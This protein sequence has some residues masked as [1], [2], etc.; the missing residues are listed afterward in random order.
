MQVTCDHLH[1]RSPDPE[2]AASFYVEMLGASITG[3][4]QNVGALRVILDLGGLTTFLEA[5]PADTT[6]APASPFV[7]IEH[8]GLLVAD[9][10]AAAAE[11][12][13]KGATFLVEPRSPA[14]GVKICFIQGPDGVRIE[15]LQRA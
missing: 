2:T 9:L 12:R 10:D 7:G 4:T 1:L 3:R 11:L 14:P 6:K 13:G 15:L 8:I 5:V